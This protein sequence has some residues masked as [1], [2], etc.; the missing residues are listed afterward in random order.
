MEDFN[1]GIRL[2]L[3]GFPT[4]FAVLTLIVL[5]GSSLQKHLIP[6]LNRWFPEED[7]VLPGPSPAKNPDLVTPEV[8]AA[9]TVALHAATKGK[10]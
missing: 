8:V 10:I 1:F 2:L 4:V 6:L 5:A 3:I 7:P 9:I